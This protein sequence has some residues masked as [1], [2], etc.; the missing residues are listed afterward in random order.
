M[1]LYVARWL[2]VPAVMS[3]GEILTRQ[4]GTPQGGAASPLLANLFLHYALD[5]WLSR[6]CPTVQFE[7]YVDDVVIHCFT[8]RQARFVRDKV[9]GRLAECGLRMHPDKTK[10]VYCRDHRRRESYPVVSFDF[11][12]FTFQPRM[13]PSE[14]GMFLGFS[15]AISRRARKR[16]VEVCRSWKLWNMCGSPLWALAVRINAVVRGWYGYYSRFNPGLCKHA[17]RV[18]NFHLRKWLRRKYKRYSSKTRAAR[19][20]Q[21]IY[22]R[23]PTLFFHWSV[24]IID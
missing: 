15:P 7:R 3:T 14:A 24:G 6:E 5:A 20:L 8:E 18:V 19:A 9:S 12:G 10:I 17:L 22:R 21:R 13:V 16:I 2:T 23:D 4:R 1:S 11:L